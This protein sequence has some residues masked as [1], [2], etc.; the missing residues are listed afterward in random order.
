[1]KL[2]KISPRFV[3]YIPDV[4]EKGVLYV[5]MEH[6]V[7]SHKCACGC[8]FETVTPISP[9]DWQIHFD[10][11]DVSLGPSIGNWNLPCR[12]H[13]WIDKGRICWASQMSTRAIDK[14][15][16]R[17]QNAK[18]RFYSAISGPEPSS[19]KSSSLQTTTD[20]VSSITSQKSLWANMRELIWP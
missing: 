20:Q 6:A 10:G 7:A 16:E 12:S 15:R 11:R 19:T 2:K 1:M 14:G 18:N 17:S 9:T 3:E 8:G 4:L 5:S 13:Y